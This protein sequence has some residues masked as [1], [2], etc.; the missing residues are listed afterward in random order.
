MTTERTQIHFLS[1]V[2]VAHAHCNGCRC[3]EHA[4]VNL[5][6]Q[7]LKLILKLDL[8]FNAKVAVE[9]VLL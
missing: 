5:W 4:R 8:F 1:D 2:L 7:G 9:M 3:N 6:C